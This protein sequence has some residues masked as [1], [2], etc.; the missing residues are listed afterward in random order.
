MRIPR[1]QI[2]EVPALRLYWSAL[3]GRLNSSDHDA[4][5][6]T[7]QSK[8][9]N[10]TGLGDVVPV[11]RARYAIHLAVTQAIDKN[12]TEIVVCPYTI[13][14]VINMITTAGARPCFCDSA[15]GSLHPT[16]E[17]VADAVT[18]KTAA[19]IITHYHTTNPYIA[20]I[21]TELR[22]RNIKLIEDCSIALIADAGNSNAGAFGDFSVFSFG[23]FKTVATPYGG[24]LYI[25]DHGIRMRVENT[26]KDS[27]NIGYRHLQPYLRRSLVLRLL[28]SPRIFTLLLFPVI[29]LAYRLKLETLKSR[30]DND[31]D[32]IARSK[33]PDDWHLRPSTTQIRSWTEQLDQAD[34][35]IAHQR[36][37]AGIYHERLGRPDPANATN[38]APGPSTNLPGGAFNKAVILVPPD[39]RERLHEFLVLAGFDNSLQFYRNCADLPIFAAYRRTLPNI[40]DVDQHVLVLPNHTRVSED[41]ARRL[42]TAIRSYLDPKTDNTR[43]SA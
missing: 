8:F 43:K 2:N 16:W 5:V 10:L 17:Q 7:F 11:S 18:D 40:T 6:L 32:P 21:S 22:Q 38:D 3:L 41:Y 9:Q 36:T 29:W 24:G 20:R 37:I 27:P 30:L 34:A 19:V 42:A 39:C 28:L 12:R 15:P 33:V 4:A 23:L 35:I 14:D 1:V 26:L 25:R 13:F 31:P